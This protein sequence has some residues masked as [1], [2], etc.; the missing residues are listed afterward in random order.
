MKS[1]EAE[2]MAQDEANPRLGQQVGSYKIVSLLG[3]GG[4]G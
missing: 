4:M 1:E 3:A 2:A